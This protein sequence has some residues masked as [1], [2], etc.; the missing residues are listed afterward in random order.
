MHVSPFPVPFLGKS[1]FSPFFDHS[2]IR[3]T[4]ITAVFGVFYR[5]IGRYIHG[6]YADLPPD[7]VG[8]SVRAVDEDACA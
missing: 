4:N 1:S 6:C 3:R 5:S 2:P 8:F 7:K